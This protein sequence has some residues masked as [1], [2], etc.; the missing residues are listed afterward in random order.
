MKTYVDAQISI[1]LYS[2]LVAGER[3]VSRSGS[4]VSEE[5]ALGTNCIG[6]RVDPRTD[7]EDVEKRTFTD[8]HT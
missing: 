4:F 2:A 3:P 7:P 5:S 8:K 1:F 6:D